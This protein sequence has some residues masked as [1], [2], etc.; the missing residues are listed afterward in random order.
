M[1]M[2]VMM[3]FIIFIEF[4]LGEIIDY[5]R[6]MDR[7]RLIILRNNVSPILSTV[8]QFVATLFVV[9]QLLFLSFW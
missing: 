1:I 7:K 8:R 6:N 2:L 3:C 4:A 9:L 5:I